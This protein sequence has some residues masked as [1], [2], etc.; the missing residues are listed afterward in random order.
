MRELDINLKN[1]SYKIIIENG[2]INKLSSYISS[3]YNN[4][5]IFIITD[6][7]VEKLY[8]SKVIESLKDKY[9]VS[10]VTVP[11]GEES[12]SLNMY[13]YVC[14]ELLKKDIRRNELLIALGGGVIGDLTGFVASSLYRGIPYV[15]IPTSLLSQMDSSIGGKTGIDFYN[16]KNILGAF[17]QP[18][19]VLIDPLTLKSLD[20]REFNNGMG[21]LIK[22]GA[23]GNKKLLNLL[24]DKPEINEDIIYESLSVK[25]K[26][27]EIDEFDLKE[28]MLLNFG[29]TFGHA[30][31]L[32][33]GYK[34]GEAVAIGMLMAIRMG[35][36]LGVTPEYCYKEILDI[37]KIY[38]LPVEEYDYK[39]YLHD[40]FYDKKNIAGT[41][42]FIFLED[43][44]N[45]IIYKLTEEEI[46]KKYN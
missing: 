41:I 37:L 7:N 6:D 4:K 34:H 8:L 17:K 3:I 19:M 21:E 28:R 14:E 26:V 15:G 27:V 42:N 20:M 24:K 1:S 45:A 33:Y 5:R 16:R 2:L 30:I 22:H 35:I 36:D 46:N 12:K 31:E 25:K 43:L 29:H 13:A 38:N 11:H 32:K 44:G 10:Y 39:K 18:K 40:V 23:I 9:V